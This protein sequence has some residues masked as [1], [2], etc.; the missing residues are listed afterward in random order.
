[1]FCAKV[2]RTAQGTIVAICDEELLGQEL[3]Y[4]EAKVTVAPE[5]YF[6][7]RID[8][9]EAIVLMREAICLNLL[10]NRIVDLAIEQGIVHRDSIMYLT[11]PSG[12]KIA[13]AIVQFFSF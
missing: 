13:Y 5:F 3:T 10:G 2:H 8:Y 7:K 12:E 4:G 6:E 11:S 9:I 1:M